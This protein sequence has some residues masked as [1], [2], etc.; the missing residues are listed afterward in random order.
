MRQTFAW[1]LTGLLLQAA[2]AGAVPTR[3]TTHSSSGVR[4]KR[5]AKKK[6]APALPAVD[7][8]AGD[9]IDGDDLSVRRAAVEA[10]GNYNGS[11]VV[12]DPETGRILTIV[13]Q[14]LAL[15]SGFTPCSTIKLVTS[16]AALSEGLISR[17][18]PVPLGRRYSLNLT[19][20]IAHSNNPY[21]AVLGARL[22][23][24][25]VRRYARMFG[26]G[27]KAGLDIPG[28]QA[29]TFPD[30][31]PKFGGMGLMTSFGEGISLTPLELA[32]LVSAISN[33]GT[34]YYLQYPR[35]QREV[36][37]FAPLVKRQLEISRFVADL[38]VGMRAAVDFGTARR[39]SYDSNEPILG[40]TGTC[41]DFR[42]A[43]HLGWFGSFNDVGR[44]KLVVVVLLTG[45]HPING[46]LAAGVA[47]SVY[48]QL[49][50]QN[51]FA[52]NDPRIPVS[53]VA[54]QSC[55]VR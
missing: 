49:S 13:N 53:L 20:A 39:A 47:G 14:K 55:C 2:L 11:V 41:T 36:E 48:R 9:N 17:S 12:T 4:R 8:T 50:Q 3:K 10:L 32:S 52:S 24:D 44:H 34:L 43:T 40:K 7:V 42:A 22:G 35:S 27:E 54:T 30:E 16:L 23:F 15:K 1:L 46:P 6:A 25:R 38:K 18:T 37:T 26:L 45:G 51:Y 31:P 21:F 29:G 19:D 5:A 28:E 33:G